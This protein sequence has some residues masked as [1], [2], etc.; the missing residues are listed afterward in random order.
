MVSVL[1]LCPP[2]PPEFVSHSPSLDHRAAQ[3]DSLALSGPPPGPVSL[4][5]L[6]IS[7]SLLALLRYF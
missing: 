1:P 6:R 7:P 4:P 2:P 5:P 3:A